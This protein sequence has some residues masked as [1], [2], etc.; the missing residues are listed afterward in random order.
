VSFSH[1][2][3]SFYHVGVS[4]FHVGVSF[5]HVGVPK[6]LILYPFFRFFARLF[7]RRGIDFAALRHDILSAWHC[8]A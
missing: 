2:G 7:L 8:G 1:V 5:F 4:F 6:F 3:V